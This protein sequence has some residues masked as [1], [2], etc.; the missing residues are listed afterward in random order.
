MNLKKLICRITRFSYFETNIPKGGEKAMEK[1]FH[2]HMANVRPHILSYKDTV[3]NSDG[4]VSVSELIMVMGN[5]KVTIPNAT[6]RW[7]R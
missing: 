5:F 7:E 4:S 6:F 2:E 1:K 3:V